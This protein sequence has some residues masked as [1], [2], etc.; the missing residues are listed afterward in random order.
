[1]DINNEY[2][3][4]TLN[5]DIVNFM[6]FRGYEETS[7]TSKQYRT[8]EID[9]GSNGKTN[10][11]CFK[12]TKDNPNHNYNL[13][14]C[15]RNILWHK[16]GKNGNTSV[17]NAIDVAILMFGSYKEAM[18]QLRSYSDIPIAERAD[19]L[20]NQDIEK[21]PA[22]IEIDNQ[23]LLKSFHAMEEIGSDGI[24]KYLNDRS[25]SSVLLSDE[26]IRTNILIHSK[27]DF[28]NVSYPAFSRNDEL[29]CYQVR[30]H[31]YRNIVATSDGMGD[32]LWY[33]QKP[34]SIYTDNIVFGETPED[35]LSYLQL[36]P[37]HLKNSFWALSTFGTHSENQT[38]RI[39]EII[40]TTKAGKFLMVQDKDI[41]GLKYRIKILGKVLEKLDCPVKIATDN[42]HINL[43][44]KGEKWDVLDK[45]PMRNFFK[46]IDLKEIVFSNH[47]QIL[48]PNQSYN[49]LNARVFIDENVVKQLIQN[50][51]GY[52]KHK[53]PYLSIHSVYPK[54]KDFNEDLQMISK[55]I[56]SL[57]TQKHTAKSFL[58]I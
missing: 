54:Y 35:V 39:A 2:H 12:G 13:I 47:K 16:E 5:V 57:N 55:S 7:A 30:N 38:N 37:I 56:I 26:R 52:I 58:K 23:K 41:A 25:I 40:T 17:G 27:K 34:K 28:Q 4:Y 22:P 51:E 3:W 45:E 49:M 24:C 46:E 9:S 6:H 20:A 53:N 21:I 11:F 43:S 19:R 8:F 50:I 31:K 36:N 14:K 33:T 44:T 32:G 18:Y 42:V 15:T 1:M 48:V 10:F 29:I